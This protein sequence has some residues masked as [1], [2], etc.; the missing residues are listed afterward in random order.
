MRFALS[1]ILVGAT[2]ISTGSMAQAQHAQ[3]TPHGHAAAPSAQPAKGAAPF[4]TQVYGAYLEMMHKKDHNPKVELSKPLSLGATDAIGAASDLRGE[5][6]IVDGKPI[7]T[8]GNPCPACPPPHAEKA[9]LLVAGKVTAWS[10]PIV[11]P[12][13]LSGHALD[14][15]IIAQANKAGLN[16]TQPFPLRIKGTLTNVAMHVIK[17]ANPKF[18]GHGSGEPMALQEDIKAASIDGEVVAYY[19]PE[20]MLGIIS[21][22]GEPFHYHWVDGA[23][24]KTAHIDN[25]GMAKGSELILPKN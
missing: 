6:T 23:R 22:P 3:P 15:F 2:S 13:D 5:I 7:V 19:A 1:I 11:L 17:A 4:A 16:M 14:Q 21:H 10:A 12:N 20:A 25:F 18:G 24:S 9:T 8:Y